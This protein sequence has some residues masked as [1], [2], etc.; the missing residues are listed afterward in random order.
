M[1]KNFSYRLVCLCLVILLIG[2]RKSPRRDNRTNPKPIEKIDTVVK[3]TTEIFERNDYNNDSIKL[4]QFLERRRNI[5]Y[6]D[7]SMNIDML[8]DACDYNSPYTK[9]FAN[10]LSARTPGQFSIEQVCEIFDYCYSKWRY[11]NDPKG[12]DYIA[13]ASE[14]IANSLIGDCDDFAVLMASCVLACGGDACIVYA[15][16]PKGC[17]VYAEVDVNSFRKNRDLSGIDDVIK[18]RYPSHSISQLAIRETRN[19][20]WLNLDWQAAYPGGPFYEAIEHKYYYIIN[21]HWSWSE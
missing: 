15:N 3:D 10:Q 5:W 8:K 2:C 12:Q 21:G 13:R 4:P 14:S 17:H 16:G 7:G 18:K 20:K 6:S 11:V 1:R 19:N 9:M